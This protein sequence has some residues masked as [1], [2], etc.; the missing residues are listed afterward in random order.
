MA[1][2]TK[3]HQWSIRAAIDHF[4]RSP[5]HNKQ[6]NEKSIIRR[7]E[8]NETII[9]WARVGYEMVSSKSNLVSNEGLVGYEI[10]NSQ[11]GA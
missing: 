7:W 5:L 2:V 8:F 11:L 9:P 10:G 3:V 6:M 1:R 4:P